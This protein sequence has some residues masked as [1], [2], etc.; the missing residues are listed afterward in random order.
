[1][2]GLIYG[3]EQPGRISRIHRAC[4]SD[5]SGTE[6]PGAET[7]N[8]LNPGR[9]SLTLKKK[10]SRH[11]GREPL[12]NSM[13]GRRPYLPA[14]NCLRLCRVV[15]LLTPFA[16]VPL[17]PFIKT[18]TLLCR[19]HLVEFQPNRIHHGG[20]FR[21]VLTPQFGQALGSVVED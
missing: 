13:S 8:G 14:R 2:P 16:P 17:D 5:F 3:A 9:C 20:P 10:N 6:P 4:L 15:S 19:N 21:P 1:M 18:L 11:V 12:F 7:I